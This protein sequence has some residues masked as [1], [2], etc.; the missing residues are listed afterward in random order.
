M[1]K[2]IREFKNY[3][4]ALRHNV[5]K[6]G[7]L[8][9]ALAGNPNYVEF[10][11]RITEMLKR[12]RFG[13]ICTTTRKSDLPIIRYCFEHN[14]PI[15]TVNLYSN[16]RKAYHYPKLPKKVVGVLAIIDKP[17]KVT[18]SILKYYNNYVEVHLARI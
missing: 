10:S 2:L 6:H 9:V 8:F 15:E 11:L 3:E 4:H 17:T 5:D 16:S 13:T 1:Q 14:I 18:N 7:V 12:F